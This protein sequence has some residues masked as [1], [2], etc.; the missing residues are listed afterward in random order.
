VRFSRLKYNNYSAILL[1]L[2]VYLVSVVARSNTITL[3][4]SGGLSINES[5]NQLQLTVTLVRDGTSQEPITLQ[6]QTRFAIIEGDA[7]TAN[8]DYQHVSGQRV[9]AAD[10][11]G[12]KT[13]SLAIIDDVIAENTE[14]F[15][16]QLSVQG[17]ATI[18]GVD[19]EKLLVSIIDNE[20]IASSKPSD[21]ADQ[22][23]A[24]TLNIFCSTLQNG[25]DGTLTSGQQA[26]LSTCQSL[27]Q[28]TVAEIAS[29]LHALSPDFAIS[30]ASLAQQI[31]G[32]QV[33]NVANRIAAIRSGATSNVFDNFTLNLN[34]YTVTP[35]FSSLSD[36]LNTRESERTPG[37]LLDSKWEWFVSG[38]VEITERETTE[39][40]TGYKPNTFHFTT[41]LDYRFMPEWILG[42]A[43][44]M[45]KG[46]AKLANEGGVLDSKGFNVL[47]YGTYYHGEKIYFDSVVSYGLMDY[48]MTR[49]IHFTIDDATTDKT[50]TSDAGG[51]Q[52]SV[53]VGSGYDWANEKAFNMGLWARL[54][55]LKTSIDSYQEVGADEF[56]VA[57]AQQ[58]VN[59]TTSVVGLRLNKA[60]S[61]TIGVVVPHISAEWIHQ[62]SGDALSVSGVF[63]NDPGSTEFSFHSDLLDTNY[64][65]VRV[66]SS[67]TLPNGISAFAE[68]SR[69]LG[70]QYYTTD[71]FSVGIRIE[72]IF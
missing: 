8:V 27:E 39:K 38:T 67:L 18:N 6:Y 45:A 57:I 29:A 52:F 51:N 49:R 68:Y 7:A 26:L 69:R 24:Q 34:G 55:Y 5:A 63:M 12:A 53:S 1:F 14:A 30:Q 4:P 47:L 2:C 28:A 9:W 33:K 56:N 71:F 3:L 64:F 40:Q 25:I 60:F 23:I 36:S 17:P 70:Q 11:Q 16:L 42:S 41:G 54:D 21:T 35:L 32:Q 50:A 44:G 22:V 13:I 31:S 43:I 65:D 20:K 72:N 61:K 37:G 66:G 59:R 46:E 10:E 19:S 58:S 15:E 48:D 62:F